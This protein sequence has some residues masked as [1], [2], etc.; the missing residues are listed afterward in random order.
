MYYNAE[1]K[2][3]KF[4][5]DKSILQVE[6]DENIQEILQ[7]NKVASVEIIVPDSRR[8][9]NGQRKKIYATLND[10]ATYTGDVPERIK[11]YFKYKMMELHEVDYFSLS[12]CSVTVAREYINLLMDFVLD[13]GVI[14]NEPGINRTD[15]I[16]RYLYKCIE[17]RTCCISGL[18]GAQIHHVDRVQMGNNRNKT[19]HANLRIIALSQEWHEKVHRYGEKEIFKKYKIYGI[20]ADIELLKK[21]K[22]N[23]LDL[24]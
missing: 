8:I 9:N 17:T 23:Y 4:S 1:I 16:D 12:D 11:E 10:I 7:R 3:W 5:E 2:R 24:K 18:K 6:I 15:D 13:W 21:L 19:N 14:L 22:L 20:K